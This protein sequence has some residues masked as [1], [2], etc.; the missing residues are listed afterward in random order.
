MVSPRTLPP[1]HGVLVDVQRPLEHP[2]SAGA[3]NTGGVI[4]LYSRVKGRW[5]DPS[6]TVFVAGVC[7]LLTRTLPQLR[8]ERSSRS[9]PSDKGIFDFKL[10]EMYS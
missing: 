10:L 6:F 4:F 5:G 1:H 9:P 3:L 2:H 7:D 8:N